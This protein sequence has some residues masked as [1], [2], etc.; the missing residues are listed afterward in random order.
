[1]VRL[2]TAAA[3]SLPALGGM[4]MTL[5]LRRVRCTTREMPMSSDHDFDRPRRYQIRVR[6]HLNHH[7]EEWLEGL[8]I[9][10]EKKG[11]TALTGMII[12]QP[13]LHG[14]LIKI[15]DMGLSL[16]SVVEIADK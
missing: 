13:Q 7:W 11:I 9:T 2:L 10:Y 5:L 1:M 3:V 15:R 16:L 4:I 6:G 12:D 8:E 14:L